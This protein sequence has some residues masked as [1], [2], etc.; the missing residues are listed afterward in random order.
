MERAKKIPTP[1]R[2]VRTWLSFSGYYL[3]RFSAKA[4]KYRATAKQAKKI[5]ISII[6]TS[7]LSGLTIP[8][9]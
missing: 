5:A 9:P 3:L 6:K 7:F 2:G 8:S 4:E 1:L